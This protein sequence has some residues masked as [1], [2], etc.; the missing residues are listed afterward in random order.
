MNVTIQEAA[1][2]VE[3]IRASHQRT[4][5]E[6]ALLVL[7]DELGQCNEQTVRLLNRAEQAEQDLR[8]SRLACRRLLRERDSA[9]RALDAHKDLREVY[10]AL[11]RSFGEMKAILDA[12]IV[13]RDQFAL[14]AEERLAALKGKEEGE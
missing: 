12:T 8:T 3:R 5:T 1:Q 7:A 11:Y 2:M 9:R 13:Q 4:E 6:Q 14:I 10:E